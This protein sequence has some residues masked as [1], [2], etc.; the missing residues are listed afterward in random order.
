MASRLTNAV[1]PT[2]V[3][4]PTLNPECNDTERRSLVKIN[5]LL[6]EMSATLAAMAEPG[7][8]EVALT[9]YVFGTSYTIPAGANLLDVACYDP[10]DTDQ[11]VY[12]MMTP[13]GAQPGMPPTF[14]VRVYAHNHAYYEAMTSS[15]SVPAGRVFSIAVSSAEN[16]LAWGSNVYLAIR[17]T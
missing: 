2:P 13:A 9:N 1:V 16:Q 17:H 8:T 4:F 14:P 11:W 7:A 6:S 10:N 5:A 3:W 12:I 15:L